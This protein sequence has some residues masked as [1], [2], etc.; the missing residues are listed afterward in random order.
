MLN[1]AF[2]GIACGQNNLEFHAS[3]NIQYTSKKKADVECRLE[4]E[5]E[6]EIEG[7]YNSA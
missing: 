6:K 5:S 7:P 2:G 3:R 1:T 4:K